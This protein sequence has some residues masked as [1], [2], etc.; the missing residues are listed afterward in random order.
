MIN[1]I[2]EELEDEIRVIKNNI[3]F[4]QSEK[5]KC[6][7][8]SRLKQTEKVIE[9]VKKHENDGWILCSKELPTEY[10]EIWITNDC[11]SVHHVYYSK[12]K[13]RFGN[14]ASESYAMSKIVAWKPFELPQLYKGE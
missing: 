3:L 11:D 10:T 6:N 4:E 2:I 5:S 9:I 13:Y 7:L 12:G 1:E 14:Y 8:I